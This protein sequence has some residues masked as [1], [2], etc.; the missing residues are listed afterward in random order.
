MEISL[1]LLEKKLNFH[2]KTA[3]R[4]CGAHL[5]PKLRDQTPLS[6]IK[7][8]KNH[9][10]WFKLLSFNL[11]YFVFFLVYTIFFYARYVQTN[12]NYSIRVTLMSITLRFQ[13]RNETDKRACTETIKKHKHSQASFEFWT[14]QKIKNKNRVKDRSQFYWQFT[15]NFYSQIIF[16]F[17]CP[18]AQEIS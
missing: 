17:N 6:T 11:F 7:K 15:R 8:K 1:S 3:H 2:L 9:K 4:G 5:V 13:T 16:L 10:L 18:K 12:S 14:W